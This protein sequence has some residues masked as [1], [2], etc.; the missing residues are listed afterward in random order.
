M[1]AAR[2][3]TLQDRSEGA[4]RRVLRPAVLV[5]VLG[6]HAAL[7]LL[8]ARWQ[9][10]IDL[11]SVE[12]LIFLPLASHVQAPAETPAA[13]DAPRKKPAS[14]RE[15]QLIIV[16]KY[17]PAAPPAEAPPAPIDWNAE[18]ALTAKQ[19]AEA[20]AQPGPR[21][22]DRHGAGLDF[23]GGLGPDV[24]AKPEFGWYHA[25]IHRVEAIEGGGSLLWLNDRCFIVMAGLI[26]FPMCG[27]GKIPPRVDLFDHMRDPPPP[28]HLNIAP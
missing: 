22:L 24:D 12:P 1:M 18:A 7:L 3:A 10:R 14:T 26:P 23:D 5:L 17:V 11:R 27:V 16:P 15:T 9:M 4:A 25:R 6:L 19:Q 20:A 8:A 2:A 28:D 21:A 13:P